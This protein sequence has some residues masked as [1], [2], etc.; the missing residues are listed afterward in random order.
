MTN[1]KR[2]QPC[3]ESRTSQPSTSIAFSNDYPIPEHC[4]G[5]K[6]LIIKA[7]IGGCMIHRIYV[8]GGSLIEIMYEHC[9]QQLS[10]E[11]KVSIRAPTSPLVDFAGQVS[12]PLGIITAPLTLFDYNRKGSKT[13]MMDF[14]IVRASSPYNVIL[15]WPGMRKLVTIGANLSPHSKEELRRILSE[16]L[17]VFTW[18][19]SDMTGIPREL[20][21]YKLNIHPRTLPIRQKKW[22]LAKERDKAITQEVTKLV[23]ALKDVHFPGWVA[24]PVMVWKSDGTWRMCIDFTSLNK[25]CPKDSYLLPEIDYK[26]ESLD[27]FR[28]KCFLDAYKGYHQIRMAEEDEDKTTFHTEHG[29]NCHF[30][31]KSAEKALPFF[32]TLKG[33]IYRKDFQWNQEAKSA[34]QELKLNLQSLPALVVPTLRETLT[35]YLAVSHETISSVLM[36]ERKNVQRPIYFV[37]KALQGPDVNYPLLKK[38]ALALVHTA[39]RLRRYF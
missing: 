35:L 2:S 12:W 6:L 37:S 23:E 10:N 9:F 14:M 4:K 27:G 13:I 5:D 36:A 7:D 39:R 22:V 33:C 38:L 21:E 31:A 20:A 28:F 30:L 26:I 11:A 32:K 25:A 29:I 1:G 15:G 18:S 3:H 19:P 34:F 8:D 17:D 24:N 16:N